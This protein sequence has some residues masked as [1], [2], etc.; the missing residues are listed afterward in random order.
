MIITNT[1]VTLVVVR[2][3]IRQAK[4]QLGR[5]EYFASFILAKQ[6]SVSYFKGKLKYFRKKMIRQKIHQGHIVNVKKFLHMNEISYVRSLILFDQKLMHSLNY[7][8][9]EVQKIPIQ[10]VIPSM[11]LQYAIDIQLLCCPLCFRSVSVY[12][13]LL[14]TAILIRDHCY[15]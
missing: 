3:T 11:L 14:S 4:E 9:N 10:H 6:N 15:G 8:I 5:I 7:F 1:Y 12:R 2:N 13:F